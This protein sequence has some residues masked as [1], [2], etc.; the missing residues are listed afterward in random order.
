MSQ[1]LPSS[2]SEWNLKRRL[3]R[4]FS[5]SPWMLDRAI[6]MCVFWYKHISTSQ[7]DLICYPSVR[8]VQGRGQPL[9]SLPLSCDW[10]FFY[11]LIQTSDAR[12]HLYAIYRQPVVSGW[13]FLVQYKFTQDIYNFLL[14]SPCKS[15]DALSGS[16][17]RF[18]SFRSYNVGYHFLSP[19][20]FRARSR[21]R[22][23]NSWLFPCTSYGL[24]VT[25]F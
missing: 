15:A 9:C 7:A 10:V 5:W 18:A 14:H 4:A 16:V 25:G 22:L 17:F 3:I 23:S 19:S 20:Q 13:I 2:V 12:V 21:L 8:V 24:I 1:L 6:T 11:F